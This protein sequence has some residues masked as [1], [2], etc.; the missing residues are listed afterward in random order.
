MRKNSKLRRFFIKIIYNSP[1]ERNLNLV[2]RYDPIV[3]KL[4]KIHDKNNDI[5]VLEVGSGT[6]GITRFYKK[7][8]I[9][10]DL[11]RNN[12]HDPGLKFI[13]ASATRL[14]F[15]SNS[16]DVVVSVD[17]LEHLSTEDQLEMV[18]EAYRVSKKNILFTYPIKFTK[19]HDK[20]A[21]TWKKSHLSDSIREHLEGGVAKG[22]EV[23]KALKGKKYHLTTERGISSRLAYYLGYFDQN[24]VSRIFCRTIL[25]IFIPIFRTMKG[26]SRKYFFVAKL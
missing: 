1:F 2:L 11:E 19:Y 13:I 24:I 8:V 3:R 5:R 21:K 10:I 14:P 22:D 16:F 26:D 25:K 15:Q 6:I 17:T 12:Y 23:K 7:E 9:G 18:R 20:I 4:K